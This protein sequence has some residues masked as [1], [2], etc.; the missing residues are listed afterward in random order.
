MPLQRPV[1]TVNSSNQL[2]RVSRRGAY[3]PEAVKREL[4]GD[5]IFKRPDSQ[6]LFVWGGCLDDY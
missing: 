5:V 3:P 4:S 2:E 1:I 6:E